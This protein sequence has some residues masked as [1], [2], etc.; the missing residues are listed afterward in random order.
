MVAGAENVVDAVGM[1]PVVGIDEGKSVKKVTCDLVN[2]LQ[3]TTT[4][5][6]KKW[7]SFQ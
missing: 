1:F 7:I 2:R 3:S 6:R 4:R 5:S